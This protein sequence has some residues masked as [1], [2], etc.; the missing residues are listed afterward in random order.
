MIRK[1]QQMLTFVGRGST[2]QKL[3]IQSGRCM[4]PV[5]ALVTGGRLESGLWSS[6]RE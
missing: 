3:Y 4:R 5:N 2:Y 6:V 1:S